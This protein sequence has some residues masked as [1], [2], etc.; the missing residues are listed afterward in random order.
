[1]IWK[2]LPPSPSSITCGYD[3]FKFPLWGFFSCKYFLKTFYYL[4]SLVFPM[5]ACHPF[6]FVVGII[7]LKG[8]WLFPW[9]GNSYLC[10]P[11][12]SDTPTR[13]WLRRWRQ[14]LE[15]SREPLEALWRGQI[16]GGSCRLWSQGPGQFWLCPCALLCVLKLCDLVFWI[17]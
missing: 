7:S 2:K 11:G 12:C 15:R 17:S 14:V 3:S 4:L 1:M 8:P 5:M 13:M 6:L 10:R 9:L 16:V